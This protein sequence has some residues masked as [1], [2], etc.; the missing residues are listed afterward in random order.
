MTDAI[1]VLTAE[2]VG[3]LGPDHGAGTLVAGNVR[4]PAGTVAIL[5]AL[6]ERRGMTWATY[7]ASMLS[8]LAW[9]AAHPGTI[10]QSPLLATNDRLMAACHMQG[11]ALDTL[12]T[13]APELTLAVLADPVRTLEALQGGD[14]LSEAHPEL[15]DE[16]YAVNLATHI[17]NILAVNRNWLLGMDHRPGLQAIVGANNIWA[18]YQHLAARA[19]N[20]SPGGLGVTLYVTGTSRDPHQMAMVLQYQPSQAPHL[21][22]ARRL[23]AMFDLS[24]P[25]R[26]ADAAVAVAV[27]AALG[28]PAQ[29][30]GELTT[31]QMVA[32]SSG[33]L[34]PY[35]LPYAPGKGGWVRALRSGLSAEAVDGALDHLALVLPLD[36]QREL[37]QQIANQV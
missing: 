15:N 10:E 37:R 24:E 11:L 35:Q 7:G 34:H 23:L 14:Y 21:R 13:Y 20:P 18:V 4:L 1:D 3:V 25:A 9:R 29:D 16:P 32:L 17:S 30:T 33:A 6:A 26:R 36:R 5:T 8:A 19:R 22:L 27:C 2:Q 28:I 31:G 12:A